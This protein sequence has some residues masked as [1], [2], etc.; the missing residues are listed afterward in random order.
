M[1]RLIVVEELDPFIEEAV[2]HKEA[3]YTAFKFRIGTEWASNGITVAKY[4]PW[5]E[6]LRAAGGDSGLS[7]QAVADLTNGRGADVIFGQS[8]DSLLL[9]AMTLE[10]LGLSLDPLSGN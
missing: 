10:S 7:V 3:G 9:G 4:I 5:L 6:K 2:R 1:D 8:G